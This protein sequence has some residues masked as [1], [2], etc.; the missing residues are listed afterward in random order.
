MLPQLKLLRHLFGGTPFSRRPLNGI[1]PFPLC[2]RNVQCPNRAFRRNHK[3]QPAEMCLLPCEGHARPC[4]NA[5]LDHLITVIQ[6]LLPE[7]RGC[8]SLFLRNNGQVKANHQPAH[9]ELLQI[10]GRYSVIF[11]LIKASLRLLIT[12]SRMSSNGNDFIFK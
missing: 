10:H 2:T 4:I 8:F 11:V 1:R 3:L 6:E 9:T 7:L 12:R 5:P